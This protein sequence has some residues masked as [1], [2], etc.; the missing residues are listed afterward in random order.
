MT[1]ET[2][3][4]AK[5]EFPVWDRTVR[6]FHWI[7]A[8]CVL[9][10]LVVGT[11]IYFGSAFGV[12][13]EGK[14]LL[15]TIHVS[16]GYVFLANLLW[17]LAWAFFGGPFARW[18]RLLPFR[19]GYLKALGGYLRGFSRGDP[20]SY[21]GHNPAARLSVTFLLVLMVNQAA[22]GLVLAGTDIYFPPFGGSIAAWVAAEGQDPA[23]LQ[24]GSKAGVD[25]AAWEEMRAFRK[26]YITLHKWGYYVL[27]ALIPLHVL[28]VIFTDTRERSGLVSAMFTGRKFFRDRPV[29]LDDAS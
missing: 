8:L 24:A 7:N 29:D 12:S 13:G 2:A 20:P 21:A 9:A 23:A 10:L 5:H 19:R 14:I 28:G 25:P 17:R 1:T 3:R 26:P 4:A 18:G 22:T 6:W 27:L 15:K 11:F 16:I